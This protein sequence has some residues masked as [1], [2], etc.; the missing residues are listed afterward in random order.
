MS[1]SEEY[2]KFVSDF[3]SELENITYRKMMGEYLIYYN[4]KVV[5]GVYDNRLLLKKTKTAVKLCENSGKVLSFELPYPGGKEMI[6][7]DFS[8]AE[9]TSA[10]IKAI[11][12]DI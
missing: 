10:I 6:L 3:L 11:A 9:F 1:S 7:S 8:D 5:G 4:G 2:L 12:S